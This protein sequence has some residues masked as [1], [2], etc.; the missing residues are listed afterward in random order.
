MANRVVIKLPDTVNLAKMS[1]ADIEKFVMDAAAASGISVTAEEVV[2]TQ[3]DAEGTEVGPMTWS[4]WT[5]AC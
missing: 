1:D 3:G 4:R 2:V 5:R